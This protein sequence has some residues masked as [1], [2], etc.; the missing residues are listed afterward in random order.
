MYWNG[1]EKT[2]FSTIL[3]QMYECLRQQEEE[4]P[5]HY[6]QDILLDVQLLYKESVHDFIWCIHSNGTFAVPLVTGRRE[7]QRGHGYQKEGVRQHPEANIFWIS[8]DRA[9]QTISY[10]EAI[11][12]IELG[13]KGK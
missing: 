6:C 7:A 9:I 11:A 4:W 5:A 12:M 8:E 3:Y 10:E 1:M 2:R 13:E